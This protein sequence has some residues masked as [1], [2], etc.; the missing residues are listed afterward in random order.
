[1]NAVPPPLPRPTVPQRVPHWSDPVLFAG[2]LGLLAVVV[3]VFCFQVACLEGTSGF[4]PLMGGVALLT[5]SPCL[6]V[7]CAVL[8]LALLR[9]PSY[10][11]LAIAALVIVVPLASPPINLFLAHG[12][13]T[14]SWWPSE[15]I[16]G[17]AMW[18]AASARPQAPGNEAAVSPAAAEQDAAITRHYEE[19]STRLESGPQ[20]IA[21]VYNGLIILDDGTVLSL[22]GIDRT[23]EVK[24]TLDVEKGSLV[25][26]GGIEVRLPD[27]GSFRKSYA[28]IRPGYGI[29]GFDVHAFARSPSDKFGWRYG[30]VPCL[31]YVDGRLYSPR[32][33]GK[34]NSRPGR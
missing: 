5:L 12:I 28:P 26:H 31:L 7:L 34:R 1:M 32:F 6:G 24:F 30:A 18:Q 16:T 14:F 22:Y 8:A 25:G 2:V 3:A 4:D 10:R 15:Q 17:N 27:E 23:V 33:L 19:L 13:G 9:R 29:G 21:E 11:V 20:R